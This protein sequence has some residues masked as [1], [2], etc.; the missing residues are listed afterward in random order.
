MSTNPAQS[1]LDQVLAEPDNDTIRLVFADWLEERGDP[2]AELIRVQV[3]RASLPDWDARQVRLRLRERALIEQHGDRWRAELPVVE[4]ITWEGFRRGF[5]A[6]A[7]F[8]SFAVLAANVRA[9]MEFTPLES[10]TIRWPRDDEGSEAIK[11]IPRLR[12]LTLTGR[13]IDLDDLERLTEAPLLTT[14]HALN[15]PNCGLS[16]VGFHGLL[17]SPHLG[18]LKALRVPGNTI[19]NAAIGALNNAVSLKSLEELDLSETGSYGRTRG[20]GR[21]REDAVLELSDI[22]ALA[23]WPGMARLKSLDLSGNA[24]RRSGLKV[25]LSSKNAIGLK[26]LRLRSNSLDGRAMQGFGAAREGLQLD[27]L[28]LGGNLV[29]DVGAS[30]LVLA[31]C[32]SQLKVLA[33]DR[34]EIRSSGARWFATAPFLDTLRTLNVNY[35]SFDPEGLYRIYEKKPPCLHTLHMAGNDLGDEGV[36]HLAEAPASDTLVDVNLNRNNLSDRAAQFL[37][38]SRHLKNLQV[39]RLSD[40]QIRK[41]AVDLLAGSPL[42]KRLAVFE[43]NSE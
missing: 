41:E 8:A 4:G 14:L 5:V 15:L 39:L 3:E 42:G 31:P 6:T 43:A 11:P 23:A 16:G 35:N 12:E 20:G 19:G 32:L 27:V 18:N 7:T 2:R 13:L 30:D 22:R 34:C 40:N 17:S 1:F 25:L 38:R 33:L 26:R 29:E 24:A 9:C 37:I 21:Y 28:D 10:I 36:A